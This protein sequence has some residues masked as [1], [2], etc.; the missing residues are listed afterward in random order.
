MP[1]PRYTEEE[2]QTILDVLGSYVSRNDLVKRLSDE[3][4]RHPS[5]IKRRY[6]RLVSLQAKS[7]DGKLPPLPERGIPAIVRENLLE[8]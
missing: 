1:G 5:G 8:E 3:L 4:G 6:E 2:D 7:P